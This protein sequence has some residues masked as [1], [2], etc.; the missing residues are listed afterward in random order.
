MHVIVRNH[1]C[2]AVLKSDDIVSRSSAGAP[3]APST[4]NT[5]ELQNTHKYVCHAHPRRHTI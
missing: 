1:L 3:A 5:E 2:V 4:V